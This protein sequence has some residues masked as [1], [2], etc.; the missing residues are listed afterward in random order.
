[1]KILFVSPEGLPFSKTGGLADVVEALPRSLVAMGHQI[2]VLLPRYRGNQAT[3]TVLPSLSIPLGHRMRFPAIAEAGTFE[4]VRYYFVDDPGYFDREKLYGDKSG[5]YPDNP[6]RF[7]ELSRAAIEFAKQVWMPDVMHCHDWQAALVP[8]CLRTVYAHDPA[9]AHLPVIFTVH[10]LGYQG[11][12]P[13]TALALAG[14]PEDL[15]HVD[16]LEYFGKVN[17]L[18]GGLVYSDYVTTV[19]RKYAQEMQTAEFGCGLEGVIRS[20]GDR[21]VG[22]LNGVDYTAWNP[23]TDTN[24]V[25][26]YSAKVMDGKRLCKKDLLAAFHL[27]A[28]NLERPLIGIVSRFVDQKGFDLIEQVAADLMKED[29]ALVA[30]GNGDAKYEKLF[31]EL[32]RKYP[33]RA[34]VKIAY[35]NVVAHKIEAGAD[36]FLMPS[37]YEPCGLNQ[38][39]SLRY[40]TVPVVRA[41]GGLDDTVEAYDAKTGKGTGFKFEAYE[42]PAL[43]QCVRQ[44]IAAYRD[45]RQWRTIQVNGMSKDFS[46]KASATEYVKLYDAARQARVQKAAASSNP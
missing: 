44:A 4:G 23:E 17:F 6:Q 33:A 12:F 19:S 35:D 37:R 32:A 46:W 26:T 28:D 41:T 10:N 40:G 9:V 34:G 15:F 8:V 29:L 13:R 27:P 2:A 24:I 36:M 25:A 42:G 7:A 39:Y 16:A 11:L 43:L 38:I 21:V 31:Q 30:L 14:L 5:D 18:K 20:R 3:R 1:M 22:I 45:L